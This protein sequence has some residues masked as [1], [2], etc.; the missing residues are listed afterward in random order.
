MRCIE[1]ENE[2]NQ[3]NKIQQDNEISVLTIIMHFVTNCEPFSSKT[4]NFSAFE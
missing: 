3:K 1:E 2:M 4:Q